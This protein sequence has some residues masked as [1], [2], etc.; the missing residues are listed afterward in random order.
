MLSD[1]LEG[2]SGEK[3]RGWGSRGRW[4]IYVYLWKHGVLTTGQPGKSWDN[5]YYKSLRRREEATIIASRYYY[6]FHF[7][8]S[9]PF[10]VTCV[11]IY[12]CQ[13][14]HEFISPL[15]ISL[16]KFKDQWETP[17]SYWK[18]TDTI[19]RLN[20]RRKSCYLKSQETQSFWR[21]S[22]GAQSCFG[23]VYNFCS[24]VTGPSVNTDTK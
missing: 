12:F 16:D 9:I 22:P 6:L 17:E 13:V 5:E 3:G 23:T 8:T 1:N 24:P 10:G 14:C 11:Y 21:S 4:H 20:Q 15:N 2:W 7:A 18:G 19:M